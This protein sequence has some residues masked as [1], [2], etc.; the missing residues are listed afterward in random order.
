M[1]QSSA[2]VEMLSPCAEDCLICDGSCNTTEICQE[3]FGFDY[4]CFYGD[5]VP[6]DDICGDW[7]ASCGGFNDPPC[8]DGSVCT[9]YHVCWPYI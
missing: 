7:G 4:E 6:S 5:C 9:N 2:H 8:C 1:R 3:C